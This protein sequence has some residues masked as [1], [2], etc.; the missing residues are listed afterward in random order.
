MVETYFKN[1]QKIFDDDTKN[2]ALKTVIRLTGYTLNYLMLLHR[3][4][5]LVFVTFMSVNIQD[6]QKVSKV[7]KKFQKFQK[8]CKKFHIVINIKS[9]E[10]FS[11]P[12]A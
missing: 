3:F 10:T 7:S 12:C 2:F 11:T 4:Y 8:V 9:G 1:I 5:F 6:V